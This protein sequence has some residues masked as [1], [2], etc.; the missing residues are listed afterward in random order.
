VIKPEEA[1]L[2][3][4]KWRDESSPLFCFA[5]LFESQTVLEG[6]VAEVNPETHAKPRGPQLLRL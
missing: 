3:F 2:L 5:D 4:T 6:T 1:V